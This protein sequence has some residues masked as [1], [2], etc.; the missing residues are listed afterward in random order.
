MTIQRLIPFLASVPGNA[1]QDS[2]KSRIL[3]GKQQLFP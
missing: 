2:D 3:G 1:K